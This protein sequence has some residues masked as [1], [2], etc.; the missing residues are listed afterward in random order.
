MAGTVRR[1]SLALRRSS[2]H[3]F[4]VHLLELSARPPQTRTGS[5][6]NHSA[7][8]RPTSAAPS[9]TRNTSRP[10]LDRRLTNMVGRVDREER[11]PATAS[12]RIDRLRPGIYYHRPSSR[13]EPTSG[14]KPVSSQVQGITKRL[15]P[16]VRFAPIADISSYPCTIGFL[17][18]HSRERSAARLFLTTD[19]TA[20][21]ARRQCELCELSGPFIGPRPP[22]PVAIQA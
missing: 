20:G 19:R 14:D 10:E 15:R 21:E 6:N 7:K 4:G 22:S 13:P 2:E 3:R 11:A 17:L 12:R 16:H 9:Q 8:S 18:L 1:D 5:R